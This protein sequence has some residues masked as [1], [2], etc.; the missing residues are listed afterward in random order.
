MLNADPEGRQAVDQAPAKIY[1]RSF[2]KIAAGDCDLPGEKADGGDPGQDLR[3][4][5]KVVGKALKRDAGQDPAAVSPK[6][7]MV[8]GK[9]EA[10][11]ALLNKREKT[12]G[13]IFI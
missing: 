2:G 10:E 8:F 9:M 11:G 6:T 3:V 4:K 12:I 5:N 1:L 7:G 13:N